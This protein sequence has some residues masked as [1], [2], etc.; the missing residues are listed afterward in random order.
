MP[1]C[2]PDRW[3]PSGTHWGACGASA[4]VPLPC[5]RLASCY[6]VSL[7]GSLRS[8]SWPE[9]NWA[10]GRDPQARPIGVHTT[11]PLCGV[12]AAGGGLRDD[13]LEQLCRVQN[14]SC[15]FV[16]QS[17]GTCVARPLVHDGPTGPGARPSAWDPQTSSRTRQMGQRLARP[18]APGRLGGDGPAGPGREG[19]ACLEVR[20]L[21]A[22][23]G[24][25]GPPV[26]G[27]KRPWELRPAGRFRSGCRLSGQRCAFSSPPAPRPPLHPIRGAVTNPPTHQ[28]CSRGVPG[29]ASEHRPSVWPR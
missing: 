7:S 14:S 16:T 2:R 18:Q 22:L 27:S 26:P 6:I 5:P 11:G 8:R 13:L 9:G 12:P 3:H 24:L 10:P 23:R 29:L 28:L 21:P 4:G 1:L 25:R 15:A 17:Q 20:P 19:N